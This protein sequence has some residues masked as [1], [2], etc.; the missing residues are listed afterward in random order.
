MATVTVASAGTGSVSS[1]AADTIFEVV[2][3]IMEFST[4]G[5]TTYMAF[6]ASEK[7]IFSSGLT[8]NYVNNQPGSSVFKH[9]AI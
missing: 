1:L 6:H 8:I 7:I 3:G 5:G 4:D 2:S 9:M